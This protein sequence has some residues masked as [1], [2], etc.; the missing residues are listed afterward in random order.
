VCGV[1]KGIVHAEQVVSKKTF[2]RTPEENAAIM[3]PAGMVGSILA[4]P[5]GAA[6]GAVRGFGQG[7]ITGFMMPEAY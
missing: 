7:T 3:V 1:G 5:V 2:E 4:V 6:H